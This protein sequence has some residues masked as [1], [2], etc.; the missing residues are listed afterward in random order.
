MSDEVMAML[1]K[2]GRIAWD[3]QDAFLKRFCNDAWM[4]V[5]VS[6]NSRKMHFVYV[7]YEGQHVCDDVPIAEWLAFMKETAP[8]EGERL[9]DGSGHPK[10][11]IVPWAPPG[12]R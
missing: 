7:L 1:N 4:L 5:K 9:P 8:S 3:N 10:K 12:Q 2:W 11:K 6:W